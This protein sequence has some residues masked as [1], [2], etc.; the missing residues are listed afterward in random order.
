MP[1]SAEQPARLVVALRCLLHLSARAAAA[2]RQRCSAAQRLGVPRLPVLG[3][4]PMRLP[5]VP[6]SWRAMGRPTSSTVRKT[7]I[8]PAPSASAVVSVVVI[9][10]TSI[11]TTIV[12]P[13]S[14]PAGMAV[15]SS[16]IETASVFGAPAGLRPAHA[17]ASSG[18][19]C[20]RPIPFKRLSAPP[21]W[22]ELEAHA[23]QEEAALPILAGLSDVS[24]G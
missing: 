14:S 2:Y 1:F 20:A 5:A 6:E 22:V 15:G 4:L 9:R 7:R 13:R 19:R 17:A 21:A 23:G 24:L 12:C 16:T 11:S 8:P 10:W 3:C 18:A